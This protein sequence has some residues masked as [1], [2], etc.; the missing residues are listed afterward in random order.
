[1]RITARVKR[2]REV[3]ISITSLA[4]G[5]WLF[6]LACRAPDLSSSMFLL[7]FAAICLTIAAGFAVGEE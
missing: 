1:M 4:G 6:W 5:L 3:I 7:V 2:L